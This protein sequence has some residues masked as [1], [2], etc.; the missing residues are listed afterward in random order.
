MQ[1]AVAHREVL[2]GLALRGGD[3]LLEVGDVA[4]GLGERLVQL[5]LLLDHERLAPALLHRLELPCTP[6][7][8]QLGTPR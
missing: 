1:E 3:V 8:L 7:P 2:C 5:L 6:S 4:A